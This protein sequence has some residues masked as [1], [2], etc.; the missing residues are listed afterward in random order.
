MKQQHRQFMRA[1]VK[2]DM[3]NERLP[4]SKISTHCKAGTDATDMN[5]AS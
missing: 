3:C 4:G 1:G 2:K 5:S